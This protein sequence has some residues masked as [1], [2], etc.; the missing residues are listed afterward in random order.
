[1]TRQQFDGLHCLMSSDVIDD[2]TQDASGIA[3]WAGA[4]WWRFGKDAPEACGAAWQNDCTHARDTDGAA[5]N[6]GHVC[7]DRKIIEQISC[8]EVVEP[9][10]DEVAAFRHFH[11]VRGID[12]IDDCFD[13]DIRVDAQQSISRSDRFRSA[14]L[15]VLFVVEH[16]PLQIREFNDI[17]I[18]KS[19]SSNSRSG[20]QVCRSG[21]QR[22]APDDQHHRLGEALL[23]LFS[24]FRDTGLSVVSSR[25]HCT[26]VTG[27][28]MIDVKEQADVF[29]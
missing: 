21:S 8:F 19:Q 25:V 16:L 23:S 28:G 26:S 18:N 12:V 22:S 1:M 10:N 17:T 7:R 24:E 6:P 20:K 3:G 5:V 27:G 14:G 9:I 2:R 29:I 15:C 13:S 4:R 11:D